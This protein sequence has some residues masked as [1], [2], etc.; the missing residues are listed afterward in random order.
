MM[1]N[2]F[3]RAED[4]I[5]RL[6]DEARRRKIPPPSFYTKLAQRKRLA[7]RVRALRSAAS[8]P[9]YHLETKLG[10]KEI[11]EKAG[12]RTAEV[13]QGPFQKLAEFDLAALP[14]KFVIKPVI[15]SGSNGVFLLEKQDQ[16][17][18]NV[19]SGAVYPLDLKSLHEA[20]LKHFEGCPLIAEELVEMHD[21][22]SLNWKVFAFYGEVGFIRQVDLNR[23]D[24][25]YKMWSPT[26][27]D[28]GVID[29]HSFPYDASLPPP[30]D[31]AAVIDAAQKISK[32][33]LTPFVRVD[34]YEAAE[35][36]YLGEV[37]LRPGSLYKRKY[38]HMFTP[39]WD[40]KLGEMW[41]EAE[42][43]LVEDMGESYL[44]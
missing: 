11:A 36:V 35:G 31:F 4:K 19:V 10:Q 18:R 14:Q 3:Q 33:V 8:G 27:E 37:T 2:L 5:A 6:Q 41:E 42:A 30:Q 21:A 43:R 39:E 9:V 23:K 15:G 40:R 7:E 38:L 32:Q 34:L 1:K 25:V 28:L 16:G 24:Q 13:F 22:P 12:V 44:P 17:L 29:R 26:G 20:G